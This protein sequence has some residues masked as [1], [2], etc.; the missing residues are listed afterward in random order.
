MGTDDLSKAFGDASILKAIG[1]ALDGL[2]ERPLRFAVAL[3]GGADSAMLAAHAALVAQQRGIEL[4]CFHVHHGLQRHADAWQTHVH[5]L[6]QLLHVACHSVCIEVNDA[7]RDGIESAARDARYAALAG[8]AEHAGVDTIMLA[9]HRNDQAETVLLRLLRGAGPTGLSAMA[10]ESLRQGFR[11]LRPLLDIDRAHIL[12][13]AARFSQLT[14]WRPVHDP[15]N[16]D[17]AYTRAAVRERLAPHLNERWPGWQSIL[18]RHARLSGETALVLDE[19]ASHDFAGLEPDHAKHSFSLAA[20]RRLSAPRQALVLR[21]WL[22]QAGLRMPSD[23][24]LHDLMRQ[25]RGLHAL[26]HD[27]QMRVKHGGHF[28][29][30]IRG[31]VFIE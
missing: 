26:G 30:C 23:A 28:V 22:A 9:H 24:R 18:A 19:V 25:M 7:G 3:S 31:R 13:Q 10:P 5:D 16:S 6:C 15:T 14:G 4:H 20:W 12:A 8:L 11:Y 2:P 21:Y 1:A 17:D 29:C 27:R